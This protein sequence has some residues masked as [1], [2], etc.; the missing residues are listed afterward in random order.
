[1]KLWV[2][3]SVSMAFGGFDQC[4]LQLEVRF[5]SFFNFD[6]GHLNKA[7]GQVGCGLSATSIEGFD[8]PGWSHACG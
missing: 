1:M 4:F 6:L 5:G 2:C 8:L 7:M 3:K